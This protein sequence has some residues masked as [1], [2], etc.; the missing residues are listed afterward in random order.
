MLGSECNLKMHA[1]NLGYTLPQHIGDRKSTFFDDFA[2]LTAPSTAYIFEIKQVRWKLQG[3]SYI[4]AKCH[5]LWSTNG[6]KLGRTFY[7]NS[8]FYFTARLRRR[9]SANGTRPN[10]AKWWTVNR[11]NNLP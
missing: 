5:E 1:R 8:V 2:N 11:A 9:R 10:F 7:P 3:V 6:L 4:V